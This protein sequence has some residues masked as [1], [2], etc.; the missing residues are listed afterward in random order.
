MG[1]C[2][3]FYLSLACLRN[4][5]IKNIIFGHFLPVTIY[6][7]SAQPLLDLSVTCRLQSHQMIVPT[8]IASKEGDM[9]LLNIMN[10]IFRIMMVLCCMLN[11]FR[12]LCGWLSCNMRQSNITGYAHFILQATKI[13][14]YIGGEIRCGF[15]SKNMRRAESCMRISFLRS[16]RILQASFSNIIW[17]IL[18]FIF[19]I[20]TIPLPNVSNTVV[21]FSF[22]RRDVIVTVPVD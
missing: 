18:I 6:Y 10:K 20:S 9:R 19:Y 16:P 22:L 17:N 8:Y 11:F 4:V 14:G 3:S 1:F 21:F 2:L 12:I 15:W 13:F 7:I 5:S